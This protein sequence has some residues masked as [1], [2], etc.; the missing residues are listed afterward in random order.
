MAIV[1]N[2]MNINWNMSYS[3]VRINYGINGFL[4]CVNVSIVKL[5]ILFLCFEVM[6]K[7][8]FEFK[9]KCL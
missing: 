8:N 5:C 2:I 9:V 6:N 3:G 7:L 1:K 4:E